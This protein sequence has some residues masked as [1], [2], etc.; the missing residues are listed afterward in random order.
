M[1]VILTKNDIQGTQVRP[2]CE[3]NKSTTGTG[4]YQYVFH[5]GASA[6]TTTY[7]ASCCGVITSNGAYCNGRVCYNCE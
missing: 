1:V 7:S 4:T 6:G 3:C 2:N 5:T